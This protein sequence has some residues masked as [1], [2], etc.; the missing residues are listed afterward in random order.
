MIVRILNIPNKFCQ[1]RRSTCL[2]GYA[3][4]ILCIHIQHPLLPE[5]FMNTSSNSKSANYANISESL[6]IPL[7]LGS[8]LLLNISATVLATYVN[9]CMP[10]LPITSIHMS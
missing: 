5:Y 8:A 7:F 6:L 4:Q 9:G 10:L 3:I 2:T 1:N